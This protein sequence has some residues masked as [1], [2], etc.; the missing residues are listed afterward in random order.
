[1][2]GMLKIIRTERINRKLRIHFVAGWQA[3]DVFRQFQEISQTLAGMLSA[4]PAE[5]VE[6]VEKQRDQL[7]TAERE[8]RRLRAGQSAC[9]ARDLDE[10]ALRIGNRR[11]VARLYDSRPAGELR[12]LADALKE[13]PDL[14][15]LLATHDGQKLVLIAACGPETGLSARELLNER[16]ARVGG[17]GGGDDQIAQGGGRAT[18]EQAEAFFQ[19]VEA[20]LEG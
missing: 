10:S 11:L 7:Q 12:A 15:T 3:L 1:M 4:S 16:L 17:R 6:L 9:E 5:V 20:A 18:P 8:L 13:Q 2:I 14:V 19:G